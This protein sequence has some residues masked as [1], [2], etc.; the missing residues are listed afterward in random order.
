MPSCKFNKFRPHRAVNMYVCWYYVNFYV[1]TII[2]YSLWSLHVR[3][4][5]Y[6]THSN[7]RIICIMRQLSLE[8]VNQCQCVY[9]LNGMFI[10]INEGETKYSGTS[11]Y[12]LN[13]FQILGLIPNR[14]YTERIFPIRNKGKINNPLPWKK[15]LLL[16]AY[17]IV[18]RWG[19][20]K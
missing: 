19:C 13:P 18:H 9:P 3:K 8:P 16:L 2:L 14:T 5:D 6:I 4:F 20:I 15:I 10:E 7:I 1:C 11:V 17:Y 12:V